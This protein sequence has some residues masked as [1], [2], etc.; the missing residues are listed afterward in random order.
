VLLLIAVAGAAV[1]WRLSP[2]RGANGTTTAP[3]AGNQA[4][5]PAGGATINLDSI[6]DVERRLQAEI[7]A[8][9]KIAMDAERRAD[10]I[11]AANRAAGMGADSRARAAEA[12]AHLYVFAEGGTPQVV[13]DGTPQPGATPLLLQV[14]PGEHQVAVR[15]AIAFAPAETTIT[16]APEDTETVIFRANRGALPRRRAGD[17]AASGPSVAARQ[18]EPV[19]ERFGEYFVRDPATGK[20]VPNWAAVTEKLGFD[21][22]TADPRR[23]TPQQRLAY[24]R[25]QQLVDSAKRIPRR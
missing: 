20:I 5:S 6:A 12:H 18:G 3:L 24:R 9:R 1:I 15:G 19:P 13:L 22:R 23:L 17:P 25:F 2:S 7:A 11:A 10:S 8:A 14:S 16:L 4:G 21:P